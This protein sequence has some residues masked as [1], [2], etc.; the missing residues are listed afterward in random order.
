MNRRPPRRT[1][2]GPLAP[3]LLMRGSAPWRTELRSRVEETRSGMRS[4]NGRAIGS[5]DEEDA[6][7]LFHELRLH[8]LELEVQNE[9]LRRAQTDSEQA[10]ARYL[11]LYQLAPVAYLSLDAMGVVLEAN[12]AA[13]ELL[14]LTGEQLL[15]S[16]LGSVVVRADEAIL[17]RHLHDLFARGG[18]ATAELRL[19]RGD[20][21]ER[22][23]RLDSVFVKPGGEE[24]RC[25][26]AMV[27]I[28][29]L[30]RR[31]EAVEEAGEMKLRAVM[32]AATDG[33]IVADE[34]GQIERLNP[35]AERMFGRT[36]AEAHGTAV[37]AL[38][39]PA[40][41]AQP[42]H[43]DDGRTS[44]AASLQ[45][46]GNVQGQRGDGSAFAVRIAVGE[47]RIAG[48]VFYCFFVRM[49]TDADD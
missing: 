1:E 18:T 36:A 20:R 17:E 35:A 7:A 6:A 33:I 23:V 24:A 14:A 16:K 2:E 39:R 9:D 30:V 3:T 41:A 11:E 29:D 49:L 42:R 19:R 8:Q 34:R 12:R 10:L 27:D 28:T 32:N 31:V 4:G 37:L 48:R 43:D 25:R 15:L 40:G 45:L 26:S 46:A 22:V 13:A 5:S 38:L 21:E 44:P 47:S